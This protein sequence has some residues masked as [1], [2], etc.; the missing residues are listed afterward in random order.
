[1][2]FDVRPLFVA[3]CFTNITLCASLF[4]FILM[5]WFG[6]RSFIALLHVLTAFA[7]TSVLTVAC[8]L[9][10]SVV[11]VVAVWIRNRKLLRFSNSIS[12]FF[13]LA[14]GFV[15]YWVSSAHRGDYNDDFRSNGFVPFLNESTNETCLEIP[16]IECC[17]WTVR[18]D[19]SC[20]P[21]NT[22]CHEQLRNSIRDFAVRVIPL[23]STVIFFQ[24]AALIF[25]WTSKNW[26][27]NHKAQPQGAATQNEAE[28]VGVG[29]ALGPSGYD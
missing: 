13:V 7:A 29:A 23:V 26:K 17:G 20:S 2:D 28:R 21:F 22:T 25:G 10:L 6:H 5:E 1:M 15:L 16:S 19:S 3:F 9:V 18:C 27:L 14:M 12:C 11:S 24:V 8:V 4:V